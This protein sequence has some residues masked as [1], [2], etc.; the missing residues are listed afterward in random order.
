MPF[1]G[2]VIL[3]TG[4]S[5]GIG[6]ACAKYFAKKGALLALVGRNEEKFGKVVEKMR[7]CGVEL[8]P[9]VILADV[10]TDAE[11][12]INETIDKYGHLDILINN[13]GFSI[14][15]TI[16]SLK[17]E[18]YDAM[19]ATN[20]RA[21]VQLTQFAIPHLVETKGNVVNV[22]SIAGL[23]PVPAFIAYSMAKAALDQFTKCLAMDLAKKNVRVNSINPG[24]IDTDFHT[25]VTG[26]ERNRAEYAALCEQAREKH[27]L[28]TIGNTD[29]CV[30][31]IAFLADENAK[32]VTGVILRIDGGLS[33]KGAF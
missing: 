12:I 21:V 8:E 30:N 26:I 32:F 9:L 2:K 5:S 10:T 24:F 17:M 16:D 25:V 31:A 20:A 11:R 13:A 23:I 33:T 3:I 14:Y 1:I 6:A 18:D 29:D 4:A 22:S 28:Q 27:P 19:M 15:G 7:E